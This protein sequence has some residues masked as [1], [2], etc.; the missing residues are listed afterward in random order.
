MD[1]RAQ[2][3][4]YMM[5]IPLLQVSL[6]NNQETHRLTIKRVAH[7]MPQVKFGYLI[8]KGLNYMKH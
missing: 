7:S 5:L 6:L 8:Q 2:I 1:S 3:N 4:Q